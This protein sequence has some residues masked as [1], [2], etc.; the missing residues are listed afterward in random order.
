M[1]HWEE[2]GEKRQWWGEEQERAKCH[3]KC[4]KVMNLWLY[5]VGEKLGKMSMKVFD[6]PGF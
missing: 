3:R 2:E 1:W 6:F 5:F 4:M